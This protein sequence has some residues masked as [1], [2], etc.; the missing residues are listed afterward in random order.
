MKSLDTIVLIQAVDLV[1][2]DRH[3]V[4][5]GVRSVVQCPKLTTLASYF[6]SSMVQGD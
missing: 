3:V 1:L 2:V 5:C 4:G 6:G